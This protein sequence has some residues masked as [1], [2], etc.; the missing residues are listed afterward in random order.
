MDEP[1]MILRLIELKPL[2]Q[3]VY[4]MCRNMEG[5]MGIIQKNWKKGKTG[6]LSSGERCSALRS[7][8]YLHSFAMI[9]L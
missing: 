7:V 8:L 6:K 4:E 1:E 5:M 9:E 3:D 2:Y